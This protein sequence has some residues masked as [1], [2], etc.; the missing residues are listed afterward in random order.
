MSEGP[1]NPRRSLGS[2]AGNSRQTSANMIGTGIFLQDPRHDLQRGRVLH[3]CS[4]CGWSV[5]CSCSPA[6]L[7]TAEVAAMMPGGGREYVYLRR[8][9]AGWS[10]SCAAGPSSPWHA[11][12]AQAA[13]ASGFCDFHER[14]DRR[15]PEPPLFEVPAPRP[16]AARDACSRSSQQGSIWTI[17]FL[18][19]RPVASARPDGA[20]TD[21]HQGAVP[22]GPCLRGAPLR[23]RRF[24][25]FRARANVG[26]TC[27]GVADSARAGLAG[28]GAAMLGALWAYDGWEQR[29]AAPRR[30]QEPGAQRA[31]RV[32]RRNVRRPRPVPARDGGPTVYVLSPTEIANDLRRIDGGHG[33]TEA[34]RSGPTPSPRSRW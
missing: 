1:P 21:Q 11:V 10:A 25:S 32:P 15:R 24:A 13:L 18:N 30:D 17:A 28:L 27:E 2:R 14:R 12:A 5:D 6:P 19:C 20:R 29:R 8:A 4:R 26:G 23:A 33:G 3:R 7:R 22:A 9:Y 31:A 34:L 16:R